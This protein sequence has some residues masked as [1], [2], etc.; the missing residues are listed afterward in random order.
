MTDRRTF[1]ISSAF[2]AAGAQVSS[3]P[4]APAVARGNRL[5]PTPAQTEGP[6]YPDTIPNDA[7]GD[8]LR[9]GRRGA[10][11][12]TPALV[13]GRV[14]GVDGLPIPGA[15]VEIWQCDA[16]G[17]YHHVRRE[18]G[19]LAPDPNFQGFGRVVADREG[20]YAFQTIRPAPYPGRTPHIHFFVATSQR[21]RLTTQLYVAGEPLNEE[22]GLFS[23]LGGEERD[24]VSR[25]FLPAPDAGLGTKALAA[26][27]D[28]VLRA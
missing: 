18:S 27:F 26:R 4:A 5:P 25:P 22:D 13:S 7:D 17:R 8:L 14:L 6:F 24:A 9:Y 28:L 10:P 20:R 1:L 15:R 3:R 2:L 12:G 23:R 11:L 21:V 19:V 16:H